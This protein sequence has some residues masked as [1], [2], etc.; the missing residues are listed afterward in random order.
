VIVTQFTLTLKFFCNEYRACFRS[1]IA[2]PASMYVSTV[3]TFK[4]FI[5]VINL[6]ED[7]KMFR[8]YM[9]CIYYNVAS[10]QSFLVFF[11]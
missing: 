9:L 10:G 4:W 11:I 6:G 2:S 1:S 8:V 7:I 5:Y 3:C